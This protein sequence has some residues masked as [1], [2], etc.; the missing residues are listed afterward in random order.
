MHHHTS[1]NHCL[2]ADSTV[3]GLKTKLLSWIQE[4]LTVNLIVM[5]PAWLGLKSQAWA[6]VG[7][8]F[9]NPEPGTNS[10]LAKAPGLAWAQPPACIPYIA[11]IVGGFRLCSRRARTIEIGKTEYET[12]RP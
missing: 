12:L 7:L 2:R 10:G 4:W 3:S 5:Y 9:E 1:K 8:G 6:L 11:L